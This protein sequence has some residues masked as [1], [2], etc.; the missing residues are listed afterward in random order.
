MTSQNSF[1]DNPRTSEQSPSASFP[2][3][4]SAAIHH[5]NIQELIQS[6]SLDA[7][8]WID[9]GCAST[10]IGSSAFLGYYQNQCNIESFRIQIK[11]TNNFAEL[12]ALLSA[13]R[14]AIAKRLKRVLIITDSM[15]VAKFLRGLLNI[16]QKHLISITKDIADLFPEFDAIFVAHIPSHK[17][18]SIENDVVDALCT[19]NIENTAPLVHCS[20]LHHFETSSTMPSLLAKL[21]V[22]GDLP[23]KSR[24]RPLSQI[25]KNQQCAHC[26]LPHAATA[27]ILAKFALGD[28]SS[29]S[30][31]DGCLS[32]LHCTSQ[33][34]LLS[35]REW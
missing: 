31:C 27:C 20:D 6:Y 35:R 14:S 30:P 25:P 17:D 8:F 10:K 3:N 9:G 16:I 33:C 28:F 11:T 22:P 12:K 32:P 5:L 2:F 15:L 18:V 24:G 13:L 21:K 1:T 4:E 19:W 7:S 23:L 26:S 29:R 34:P